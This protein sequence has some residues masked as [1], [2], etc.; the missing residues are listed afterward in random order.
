[1]APPE[2]AR[3][4]QPLDWMLLSKV[5][6]VVAGFKSPFCS[7]PLEGPPLRV[8]VA[9]HLASSSSRATGGAADGTSRNSMSLGRRQ[10]A[11]AAGTTATTPA[12]LP[13][14]MRRL[15]LGGLGGGAKASKDYR[16]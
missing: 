8:G 7:V 16:E 10:S 14:L 2:I 3:Y 1:V 9:N 5:A 13:S 15:S 6:D 12:A 4:R 11:S